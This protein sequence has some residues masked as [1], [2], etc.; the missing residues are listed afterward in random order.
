MGSSSPPSVYLIDT[1]DPD[2]GQ[3][4]DSF[5]TVSTFNDKPQKSLGHGSRVDEL[6]RL[7]APNAQMKYTQACDKD[8]I[9]HLTQVIRALCE[10]SVEAMNDRKVIVH[11][12]LAT[13][14][15]HPL[16]YLGIDAA[17]RAGAAVVVAYGNNDR[18]RDR[19]GGP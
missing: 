19:A 3:A 17:A 5:E 14:Y 11:L 16:L 4:S 9:C 7:I 13:P 18:C 15:D 8:G 10:A 12:S 2:K 1:F 6:I